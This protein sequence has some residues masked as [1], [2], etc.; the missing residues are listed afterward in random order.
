MSNQITLNLSPGD[1]IV[2]P[3]SA[4]ELVHHHAIY[5]GNGFFYENKGWDKVRITHFSQLLKGVSKIALIQRF[6]GDERERHAALERA[7]S[8]IGEP[9]DPITFNCEHSANYVQ[10]LC[11]VSTQVK[12][13]IGI[14]AIALLLIVAAR[15][16]H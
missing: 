14:G 2:F 1:R 4:F 16:R 9:Y 13:A 8:M 3:K 11:P 7:K 15:A 10:H 12:N 6:T 5:A